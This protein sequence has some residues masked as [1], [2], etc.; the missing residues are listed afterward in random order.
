[1]TSM[2]CASTSSISARASTSSVIATPTG[3]A[4]RRRIAADREIFLAAFESVVPP[5]LASFR[6]DV[7]VAQ[8]GIDAHRTDPLTHLALDIQG[9][10]RA[11]QRIA[12]MAPR[13]V[14]LGGGGY[15]L[16]NVARGWT[17]S[18]AILNDLE[19]PAEMP[20]TFQA[21]LE[22][23]EFETA[24]L[25]DEP[26]RLNEQTRQRVNEYVTRQ[27]AAVKRVIFP[28]HGL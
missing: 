20:A 13:L 9:F 10:A 24:H 12:E 28:L 2:G 22:R 26:L 14:A 8:L 5:L 18:W 6:P 11:V 1:M 4:W 21:D 27:V 15:D 16:R 19:L 7:I 3:E 17:L 25:L 23:Y